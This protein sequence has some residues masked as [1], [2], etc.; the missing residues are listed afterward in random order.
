[1]KVF[2]FFRVLSLIVISWF[3]SVCL[4]SAQLVEV[5]L[6]GKSFLGDKIVCSFV[7]KPVCNLLPAPRG[8][9][10]STSSIG[11]K[12][13]E[14]FLPLVEV[15][16]EKGRRSVEQVN[17]NSELPYKIALSSVKTPV[18]G[19]KVSIS[20][21]KEKYAL[22]CS[23]ASSVKTMPEVIF[24][25]QNKVNYKKL[26]RDGSTVTRLAMS[27]PPTVCLDFGHGGGDDGTKKYGAKE[28]NINMLVGRKLARLLRQDGYNV[29]LTRDSDVYVSLGARTTLANSDSI[30]DVLLSLHANGAE[31][32]SASGMETFYHKAGL[33]K[34]RFNSGGVDHKKYFETVEQK[35]SCESKK[36]ATL[37]QNSTIEAV[38][39]KSNNIKDRGVKAAVSQVLLGVDVP[40]ALIEMGFLTN[41]QECSRLRDSGYQTALA[42]GIR[43]GICAYLSACKRC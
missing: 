22:K 41:R 17:K 12:T 3:S 30:V 23:E 19:V 4:T 24:E 29:V 21:N 5:C 1:M 38:K 14:F 9:Y 33:L 8:E 28:K 6:H 35:L 20:Y 36:L 31:S 32:E 43:N 15:K 27:E 42:K 39:K 18:K 2:S 13:E 25:I 40:A 37:I 10:S 26:A 34:E 7:G 16:G 11:F